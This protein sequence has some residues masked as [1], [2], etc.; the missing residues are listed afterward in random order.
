M[1]K[2]IRLSDLNYGDLFVRPEDPGRRFLCLGPYGLAD[3]STGHIYAA[4][5]PPEVRVIERI[6]PLRGPAKLSA[7]EKRFRGILG[8]VAS[9]PREGVTTKEV[10]RRSQP[11]MPSF[12]PR[13]AFQAVLSA[14]TER[15]LVRMARV[16]VEEAYCTHWEDG[17]RATGPGLLQAVRWR[18]ATPR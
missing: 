16:A 17:Y 18:R 7:R 4:V 8:I 1:A 3:V 14:L 13:P 9:M 10:W 6:P 2:I 5:W 15:G 11:L 12:R